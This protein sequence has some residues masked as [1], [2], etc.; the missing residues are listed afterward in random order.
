[1]TEIQIY[2][3]T[4]ES[5]PE[6]GWFQACLYCNEITAS[7]CTYISNEYAKYYHFVVYLCSNCKKNP[8]DFD[9]KC[10]TYIDKLNLPLSQNLLHLSKSH[11]THPL[12]Q[13]PSDL[14]QA[15]QFETNV[16]LSQHDN[17][18]S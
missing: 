14:N 4:K 8:E 13:F 12:N 18:P 17:Q 7:T 6:K 3:E 11:S 9:K 16:V 2:G 10:Q 5:L 15:Q 1:M